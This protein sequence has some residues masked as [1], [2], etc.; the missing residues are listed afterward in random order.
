M[1]AAFRSFAVCREAIHGNKTAP[2]PDDAL[3]LPLTLY[4][5]ESEKKYKEISYS[6]HK[7]LN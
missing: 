3:I 1:K 7:T 2:P 4:Y 5:A 6:T